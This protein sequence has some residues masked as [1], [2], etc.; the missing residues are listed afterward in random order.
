[1]TEFEKTCKWWNWFYAKRLPA[2]NSKHSTNRFNY[3]TNWVVRKPS[4]AQICVTLR[5]YFK[6]IDVFHKQDQTY[7]CSWYP[8]C[9]LLE[10]QTREDGFSLLS[11]FFKDFSRVKPW[12]PFKDF[13]RNKINV[14]AHFTLPIYVRKWNSIHVYWI[15]H[16][17]PVFV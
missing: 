9:T 7:V 10:S 6:P 17:V 1:M 14:E 2:L 3:N 15:I 11:V 8:A 13:D 16:Y 5:Q 4:P 12:N